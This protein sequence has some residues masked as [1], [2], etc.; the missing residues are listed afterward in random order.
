MAMM[1][2]KILEAT[3]MYCNTEVVILG[4]DVTEIDVQKAYD[5]IDAVKRVRAGDNIRMIEKEKKDGKI[6]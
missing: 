4:K 3:G 6:S 2:L 1:K 5:V